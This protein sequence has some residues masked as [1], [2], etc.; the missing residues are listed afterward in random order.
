MRMR[1]KY[2]RLRRSSTEGIAERWK[3]EHLR[4]NGVW[5]DSFKHN[6]KEVYD[7]LVALGPSPTEDAV[8][9]ILGTGSWT[10]IWCVGC[11]SYH[12]LA[13]EIGEH[14]PR[15]YCQTCIEEAVAILKGNS[16]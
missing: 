4:P 14:E 10:D 7:R 5:I 2:V 12:R 6:G 15:A 8:A 13:V 11:G 16:T 3:R 9:E 1:P